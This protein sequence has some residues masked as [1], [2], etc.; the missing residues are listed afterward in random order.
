MKICFVDW[1]KSKGVG[2]R[3]RVRGEWHLGE[4][5]QREERGIE[6]ES[7]WEKYKNLQRVLKK[8]RLQ[9]KYLLGKLLSENFTFRKHMMF[10]TESVCRIVLLISSYQLY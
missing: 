5:D 7:V 3:A 4:K 8:L 6:G 9:C 1:L 2:R 10:F